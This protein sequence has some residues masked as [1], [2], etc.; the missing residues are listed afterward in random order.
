[1]NRIKELR[2]EKDITVKELGEKFG[3]SQSMLTNYENGSSVPRDNEIWRKLADYF[4]VSVPYIMGLTNRPTD[5]IK[6]PVEKNPD[7]L[8][9]GMEPFEVD[10]DN[11]DKFQALNFLDSLDRD[12]IKKTVKF[13]YELLQNSKYDDKEITREYIFVADDMI[14]DELTKEAE[15]RN[16]RM[17][18]VAQKRTDPDNDILY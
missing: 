17:A 13:M 7:N 12:D 8:F 1:M 6:T 15:F 10:V 14:V 3:I 2:K 11:W 18:A 9:E 5:Y 16:T 4:D